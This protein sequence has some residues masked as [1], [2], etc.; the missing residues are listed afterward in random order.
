MIAFFT[1]L[2]DKWQQR[3]VN[4]PFGKEFWLQ[5]QQDFQERDDSTLY[6]CI[7]SNKFRK[8]WDDA[9]GRK[10][11]LKLRNEFLKRS[12]KWSL[13]LNTAF[14]ESN[15]LFSTECKPTTITEIRKDFINWTIQQIEKNETN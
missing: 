14:S 9:E 12:S 5:V 3:K 6:L 11:L 8:K 4:V 2:I 1:L 10:E 15:V 13:R 7:I